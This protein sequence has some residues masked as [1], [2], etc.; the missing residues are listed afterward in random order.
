MP[1]TGGIM[2]A[3][4]DNLKAFCIKELKQRIE[5]ATLALAHL[6]APTEHIPCTRLQM[7]AWLSDNIQEFR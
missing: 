1:A 4:G 2:P 5:K 7:A 6:R 3:T